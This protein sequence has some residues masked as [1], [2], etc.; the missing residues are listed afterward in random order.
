M[1]NYKFGNLVITNIS[2]S[3]LNCYVCL[4]QQ[5]YFVTVGVISKLLVANGWCFEGCPNCSKKKD[6]TESTNTCTMCHNA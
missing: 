3:F 6:S 2:L 5:Y 1:P 4:F